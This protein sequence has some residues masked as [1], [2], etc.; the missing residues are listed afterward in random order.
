MGERITM[1][2]LALE[3]FVEELRTDKEANESYWNNIRVYTQDYLTR[4]AH[5]SIRQPYF[6]DL[7]GMVKQVTEEMLERMCKE[8]GCEFVPPMD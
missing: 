1:Q 5:Y 3:K 2:Y 4:L 7:D 8:C 6:D